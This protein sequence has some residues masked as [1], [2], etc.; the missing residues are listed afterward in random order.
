M[1]EPCKYCSGYG[2]LGLPPQTCHYCDGKGFVENK[3]INKVGFSYGCMGDTL[4]D[5]AAKQ[6]F[7]LKDSE[8]FEKIRKAINMCGFH[9]A[10]NSQVDMMFKKLNKQVVG[11]LVSLE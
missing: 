6:G 4:E 3:V 1:K 8:K 10:T 5:Q 7:K 2:V 9:V 11:N